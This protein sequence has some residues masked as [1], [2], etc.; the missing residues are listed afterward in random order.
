VRRRGFIRDALAQV[1]VRRAHRLDLGVRLVELLDGT[2]AHQFG[3]LPDGPE[4]D[5]RPEQAVEV[6]RVDALGR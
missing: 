4:R 5:L 2:A 6:E 1:R 3:A